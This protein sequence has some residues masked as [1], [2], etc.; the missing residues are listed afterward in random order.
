MEASIFLGF[1]AS[2]RATSVCNGS[3]LLRFELFEEREEF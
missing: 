3:D 1:M 2:R